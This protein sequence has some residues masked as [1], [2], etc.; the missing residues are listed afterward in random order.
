[1]KS[2]TMEWIR[3][4][5][6]STR[7]SPSQKIQFNCSSGSSAQQSTS[8]LHDTLIN[9]IYLLLPSLERQEKI[10][11]VPRKVKKSLRGKNFNDKKLVIAA[12]KNAK[13]ENGCKA[14]FVSDSKNFNHWPK[15]KITWGKLKDIQH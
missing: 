14:R 12:E 5:E 10:L 9:V 2:F 13:T 15:W 8:A 6:I 1:M 11:R 7:F 3:L 4:S